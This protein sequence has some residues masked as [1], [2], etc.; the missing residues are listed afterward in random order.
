[1]RGGW[2][3]DSCEALGICGGIHKLFKERERER[4]RLSGA[5]GHGTTVTTP[6]RSRTADADT[7]NLKFQ[8]GFKLI[9]I[10]LAPRP[11]T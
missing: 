6:T 11:L 5:H 1:M 2:P 7:S 8:V 10:N 4:S 9:I 3:C